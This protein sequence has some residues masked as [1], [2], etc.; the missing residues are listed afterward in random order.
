MTSVL[1]ELLVADNRPR[2]PFARYAKTNSAV[3][4]RLTLCLQFNSFFVYVTPLLGGIIADAWWGRYKTIMVFSI[5][6]LAG[7]II[8]VGSA[9]PSALANP[10]LSL[11]L[12]VVSIL[13]IVRAIS[14]IYFHP[15]C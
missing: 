11:G 4:W 3:D 1:P 7:H 10:S 9:T 14:I 2:M 12:L 6:C 8:L 13:I 15:V 5:I